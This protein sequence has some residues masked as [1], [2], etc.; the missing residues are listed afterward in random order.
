M[1]DRNYTEIR[2]HHNTPEE[3]AEFEKILAD[4]VKEYGFGS[5]A[6][7]IRFVAVNA[8]IKVTAQ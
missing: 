2:I 7:Y 8:E 4:K 1:A 3:K 5:R 6:E